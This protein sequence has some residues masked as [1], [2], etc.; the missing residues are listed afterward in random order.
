MRSLRSSQISTHLGGLD[1][2]QPGPAPLE[3][4]PTP[5]T[6][7]PSSEQQ[8]RRSLLEYWTDEVTV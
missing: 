6:R 5:S 2:S 7:V 3:A 4:T 8:D 1:S